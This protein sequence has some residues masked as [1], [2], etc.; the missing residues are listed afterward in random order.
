M[1][2]FKYILCLMTLVMSG[3][4]LSMEGKSVYFQTCVACHGVDGKGVLPGVPDFTIIN[5]RL[6]KSDDVLL[7]N[8]L[9][10]MQSNSSPMAMPAKGGNS[11]LNK[12]DLINVLLFMRSTFN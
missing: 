3:K 6:S 10:G 2:C 12:N 8:M 11:N 4:A 5:S 9:D 7:M 1:K